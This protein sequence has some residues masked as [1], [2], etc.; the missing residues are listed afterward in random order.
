MSGAA[1]ETDVSASSAS[2][3]RMHLFECLG[4]ELDALAH[5]RDTLGDKHDLGPV[6]GFRC[7][8]W[9]GREAEIS[10]LEQR[11]QRKS[12]SRQHH[13]YWT[14]PSIWAGVEGAGA[15]SGCGAGA[16]A[17]A[18]GGG[19]RVPVALGIGPPLLLTL[20]RSPFWSSG[21]TRMAGASCGLPL[22][23]VWRRYWQAR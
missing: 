19:T 4:Q 8:R 22:A 20:A 23:W 17:G 12:T 14:L 7:R 1:N 18:I 11:I 15:T 16:G 10:I 9:F 3:I 6:L 2:I 13:S 5:V 21:W